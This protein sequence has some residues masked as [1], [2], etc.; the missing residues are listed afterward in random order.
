MADYAEGVKTG[1]GRR[2]PST[3]WAFGGDT[4]APSNSS[5]RT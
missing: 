5:S 2:S 1:E 3:V 4:S